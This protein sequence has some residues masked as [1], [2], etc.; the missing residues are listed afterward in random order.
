MHLLERQTDL[1]FDELCGVIDT[2]LGPG[3][4]RCLCLN[5][6]GIVMRR[7]GDEGRRAESVLRGMLGNASTEDRYIAYAY[8]MEQTAPTPATFDALTAFEAD[9]K[10]ASVLA[11]FRG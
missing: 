11:M 6:I 2:A 10:N 3:R 5:E 9:P 7:G 4:P 1:S 8:L